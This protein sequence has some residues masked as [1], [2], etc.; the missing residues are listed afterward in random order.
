ME[1]GV[2]WKGETIFVST[3]VGLARCETAGGVSREVLF[4]RADE[5]LYRAKQHGR[6]R[7]AQACAVANETLPQA[8]A[9]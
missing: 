5:A 3:S 9:A 1:T 4:A 6:N 7:V 8:R 2:N